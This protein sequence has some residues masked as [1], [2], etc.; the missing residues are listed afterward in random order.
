MSSRKEGQFLL[1]VD[2]PI[3]SS[4]HREQ[5]VKELKTATLYFKDLGLSTYPDHHQSPVKIDDGFVFFGIDPERFGNNKRTM[6]IAFLKAISQAKLVYVVTSNGYL[7]KSAS[8]ELAYSLLINAPIV[9]SQ[10]ITD[11]GEEVPQEIKGIIEDNQ[12]LLSV[13]PIKKIKELR[14]DG[15][16]ASLSSKEKP[17]LRILSEEDKKAIL[18]SIRSLVR[19]LEQ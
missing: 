6:E 10:P 7:G 5:H 14:K 12:E 1:N 15:L 3:V 18:L 13:I 9:L 16:L 11:F 8:I 19:H 4:Y 2:M 17:P